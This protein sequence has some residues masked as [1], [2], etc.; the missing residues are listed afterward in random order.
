MYNTVIVTILPLQALLIIVTYF[1][2]R[3]TMGII[4]IIIGTIVITIGATALYTLNTQ[5]PTDVSP[6][7]YAPTAPT[8][9]PKGESPSATPPIPSPASGTI[10]GNVSLT[11]ADFPDRRL[12]GEDKV[13]AVYQ[14]NVTVEEDPDDLQAGSTGGLIVQNKITGSV[15]KIQGSFQILSPAISS[16]RDGKYVF[17]SDG[18]SPQRAWTYISVE[19]GKEILEG[20]CVQKEPLSWNNYLIYGECIPEIIPDTEWM[21]VGVSAYNLKTGKN[22]VLAASNST[23]SYSPQKISGHT[24]YFKQVLNIDLTDVATKQFNLDTLR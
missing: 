21:A 23:Y 6:T 1:M 14:V 24:L 16:T 22:T 12:V 7:A 10:Q 8:L 11:L 2:D 15:T 9:A 13:V 3:K 20:Y 18:T 4:A 19:Q 5:R 17:L